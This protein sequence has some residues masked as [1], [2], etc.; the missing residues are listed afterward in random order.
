MNK[1]IIAPYETPNC[2][3]FEDPM[4]DAY[5]SNAFEPIPFRPEPGPERPGKD[6]PMIRIPCRAR[7]VCDSHTAQNAYFELTTDSVH[8]KILVCSHRLCRESGRIFRYCKVCH[9][10]TAK[11]N[12]SKRHAH[13][14]NDNNMLKGP[15]IPTVRADSP[16]SK[17]KKRKVSLDAECESLVSVMIESMRTEES[18][19]E[20]ELWTDQRWRTVGPRSVDAFEDP[21]SVFMIVSQAE[22]NLLDLV[23]RRAS[24]GDDTIRLTQDVLLTTDVLSQ[25]RIMEEEILTDNESDREEATSRMPSLEGLDMFNESFENLMMK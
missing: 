16:N 2:F 15:D 22:A 18:K 1:T 20:S 19:S 6:T 24:S 25:R 4:E 12:F 17:T 8:G 3:I 13:E 9:Q 23:R 5:S 14:I 7:G 10:V 11:R 21:D